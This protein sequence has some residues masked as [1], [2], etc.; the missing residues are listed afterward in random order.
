MTEAAQKYIN[1]ALK[2]EILLS[3]DTKA[4]IQR[5]LRDLD[6]KDFSYYY[7]PEAGGV[8]VDFFKILKHY[9]GEYAGCSF[10]LE[11]WQE[12]IICCLFGWKKK[13]NNY[14]RFKYC[15]IEIPR[16]NGKTTLAAGIACYM[17]YLDGEA[18]AEIYTGATMRQQAGICFD[19]I[20]TMIQGSKAL[21]KRSKI[22]T[23]NVTVPA[24]KTKIEYVS[25]DADTLD[26][27]NP[28]C[29]ILDEIHAYRNS[30]LYDV[31]VSAIGARKQPLI[32]MITTAGF[33]KDWFCYTYRK[34]VLQVAQ[35]VVEDDTMF[36]IV[37]KPDDDDKWDS[38]EAIKKSNPN[39]DVSVSLEYLLDQVQKA[40]IR[41]TE[42]VNVKTKHLNIW[43]DTQNS[44]IPDLDWL[45]AGR[46][47]NEDNLVGS[48]CYGGLDLA[49]TTDFASFSLIFAKDDGTFDLLNWS[50]LPRESAQKR[51]EDGLAQLWEWVE[52]GHVILTDKRT[53]DYSVIKAF[54]IE[55][56]QKYNFEFL[57]KDTW[58]SSH[59]VQ[60]LEEVLPKV[61]SFENKKYI[62]R[63]AD[64]KQGMQFMSTPTKE[65]EKMIYEKLLNHGNNPLLRW[66]CSNVAIIRDANGNIK[67]DKAKSSESVDGIVA[68]VMALGEYMTHNWVSFQSIYET[69]GLTVL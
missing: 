35:G 26:G 39:L 23:H 65:F 44:W 56:Y 34:S 52:K 8:V 66:M 54:I 19:D 24:S 5:H 69:K 18:G 37:Y 55:K 62:S 61:Y 47:I 64:F 7:D 27:L 57:A 9:K 13:S 60:E 50:F 16:K 14:R 32:F 3:S 15:Y 28:H 68:S 20:K 41:P 58:N 43:T 36:G 22:L 2:G 29:A 45:A 33:N 21:S 1:D 17:A 63:V 25:S 59:L 51:Y 49:S 53:T 67:V 4:T 46:P 31:F 38:I 40:R 6:K 48:K 30:K 12:F 42:T 11:P 10:E